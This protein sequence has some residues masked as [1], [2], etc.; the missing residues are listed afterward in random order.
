MGT[1]AVCAAFH[2]LGPTS[3]GLLCSAIADTKVCVT[4]IGIVLI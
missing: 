1:V 3:A 4:G 2:S